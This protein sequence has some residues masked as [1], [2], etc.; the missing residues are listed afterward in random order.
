MTLDLACLALNALWGFCLVLLEIGGKTRVAGPAWNAGNR[1]KTPDV[2]EWVARAGRAL[3]N[4][5][6][7]FPFFATAVLVVHLAGR[8]DRVTGIAAV[9]YVVARLAHAVVYVAGITGVRS[10][11]FT[12]GAIATL[13]IYGKLL[14]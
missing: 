10:V 13:V 1:D 8:A 6:E 7:N 3:A 4:H 5:K 2:P 14:F 12:V 11:V 9:V